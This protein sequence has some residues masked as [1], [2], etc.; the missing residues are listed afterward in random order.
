LAVALQHSVYC[1]L[2][3]EHKNGYSSF[4]ILPGQ[5]RSLENHT[6]I[7][8]RDKSQTQKYNNDHGIRLMAAIIRQLWAGFQSIKG[9]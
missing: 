5:I 9:G 6:N 4:V 8:K 7:A 1:A 3:A 2:S